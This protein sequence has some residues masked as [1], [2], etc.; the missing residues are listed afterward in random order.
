LEAQPHD[1]DDDE[2]IEGPISDY[3]RRRRNL[4]RFLPRPDDGNGSAST[5]AARMRR[6]F[7]DGR[8]RDDPDAPEGTEDRPRT[9]S[10][11]FESSL[12]E[13]LDDGS[14]QEGA[15]GELEGT[16]DDPDGEAVETGGSG[17]AEDAEDEEGVIFIDDYPPGDLATGAQ[18]NLRQLAPLVPRTGG[19]DNRALGRP[20]QRTRET[21]AQ[22]GLRIPPALRV[23]QESATGGDQPPD[24][25]QQAGRRQPRWALTR[26]RAGEAE[27]PSSAATISTSSPFGAI[28]PPAN[29]TAIPTTTTGTSV[30]ASRSLAAAPTSTVTLPSSDP[31]SDCEEEE[32]EGDDAR[33]E[34]RRRTEEDSE[35]LLSRLLYPSTSTSTI[36]AN[37][38]ASGTA[39]GTGHRRGAGVNA[40]IV[41]DEG[42]LNI[43]GLTWDPDGEYLYVSSERCVCR[44]AVLR[45]GEGGDLVG[46]WEKGEV[47]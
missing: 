21:G 27:R 17:N 47:R 19:V 1:S 38:G 45:A 15:T 28:F 32:E 43:S 24:D 9:A 13:I 35:D 16:N 31:D 8:F 39:T 37:A 44:W 6:W 36:G 33:E 42:W 26:E 23:L 20:L 4:S 7:P 18:L 11:L 40:G 30:P 10:E 34:S 29:R 41:R 2:E 3:I 46:G 12:A 14:L 5:A 25:Q 22:S